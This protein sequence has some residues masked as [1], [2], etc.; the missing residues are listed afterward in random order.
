MKVNSAN[1]QSNPS[2]RV[3]LIEDDPEWLNHFYHA[4]HG[5]GYL[6]DR[7]TDLNGARTSLQQT[8]AD[9]VVL[10]MRLGEV[11]VPSQGKQLLDE[12]KPP[13]YGP[14]VI[15]VTST[16]TD[17]GDIADLMTRREFGGYEIF[18]F[19]P[20]TRFSREAFRTTVR[21]AIEERQELVVSIPESLKLRSSDEINVIFVAQG[22]ERLTPTEIQVLERLVA[23]DSNQEIAFSLT[24]SI[25]TIKTHVKKILAKLQIESRAK[26]LPFALRLGLTK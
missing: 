15:V 12:M 2:S 4:L 13:P 8:H 22:F 11:S 26:I 6:V 16:V 14:Q 24:V 17:S 7:A 5:E 3:L 18:R 1:L 9:V 19:L 20:K 10:D 23:G 25:N 21:R